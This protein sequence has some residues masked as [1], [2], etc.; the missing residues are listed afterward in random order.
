M[1]LS[2]AQILTL[3]LLKY[4]D[5]GKTT[6]PSAPTLNP[7]LVMLARLAQVRPVTQHVPVRVQTRLAGWLN[8][9]T[10]HSLAVLSD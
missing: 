7:E 5:R 3:K 6:Q 4:V 9:T 1:A 2:S 8:E 10:A